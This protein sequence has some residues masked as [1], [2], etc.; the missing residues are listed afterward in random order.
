GGRD[1]RRLPA[2][3]GPRDDARPS[4]AAAAGAVGAGGG[5]RGVPGAAGAGRDVEPGA[6]AGM[7]R[8]AARDRPRPAAGP[9]PRRAAVKGNVKYDRELRDLAR[10]RGA[11]LFTIDVDGPLIKGRI[12]GQGTLSRREARQLTRMVAR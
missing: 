9:Q 11:T 6:V 2:G 5:V 4:R 10:R 7:G 1:A 3:A 12:T 8:A